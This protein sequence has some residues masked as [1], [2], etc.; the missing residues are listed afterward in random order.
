MQDIQEVRDEYTGALISP[1]ILSCP[2]CGSYPVRRIYWDGKRYTC[3]VC[4][5]GKE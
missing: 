4:D 3:E 1:I 2:H 5:D